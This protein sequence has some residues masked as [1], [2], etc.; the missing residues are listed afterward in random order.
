MAI[1]LRK[2]GND[3]P[4]N[5]LVKLSYFCSKLVFFLAFAAAVLRVTTPNI[6]NN[7]RNFDEE[8]ILGY[9]TK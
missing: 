7:L 5:L 3:T 2:Y 1:S 9:V 6:I 4:S 8:N